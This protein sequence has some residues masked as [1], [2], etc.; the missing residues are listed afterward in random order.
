MVR[1]GRSVRGDMFEGIANPTVKIG[2]R[3]RYAVPLSLVV[4]GVTIAGMV[5]VP[6]AA[7]NVPRDVPP[8]SSMLAFVATPLPPA[9][10]PP[11]PPSPSDPLPVQTPP[12]PLPQASSEGGRPAVT[13]DPGRLAGI[14][15]RV[16]G[17]VAG[18][19]VGGRVGTPPAPPQAPPRVTPVRVGG[20][21]LP[22]TKL[23]DIAPLYPYEADL[24]GVQGIVILKATIGV[25]GQITDV[26]VL[27]SIPLLDEAALTAVRQWV[28]TPTLLNG[29][30]V[31]VVLTVTVRFFITLAESKG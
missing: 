19:I 21:I 8:A 12:P 13:F 29:V 7:V 27:R 6:A 3:K 14:E 20:K 5:V 9:P 28:Y 17:G 16:P 22:P 15:S 1:R 2:A 30:P 25:G 23:R 26:E 24:A 18:G 31:P 11:P 10:A 4:H